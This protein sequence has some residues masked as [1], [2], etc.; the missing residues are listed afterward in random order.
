M[1]NFIETLRD[2]IRHRNAS[3]D[4]ANELFEHAY[5]LLPLVYSEFSGFKWCRRGRVGKLYGLSCKPTIWRRRTL[6]IEFC[7][8]DDEMPGYLLVTIHDRSNHR[9]PRQ[10]N[11]NDKLSIE[12]HIREAAVDWHTVGR[13]K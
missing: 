5:Y 2:S 4:K 3:L 8:A 1:S 10:V 13:Y 12:Q 9:H 7:P 11:V 6:L